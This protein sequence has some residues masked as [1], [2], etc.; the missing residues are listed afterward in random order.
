MTIS[1]NASG[2]RLAPIT[3]ASW[4]LR[5]VAVL[6]LVASATVVL[7]P[8]PAAAT[9]TNPVLGVY[10]GAAYP[11]SVRTF[12]ATIGTQPPFAMDFLN[13]STWRTITQQWPYSYWKGKGYT[14]VW[15]VNMLP[16][17]YTPNT[18]PSQAGGSC[19]GLTQGATG[20]FDHYFT[21]VA[22][23]IVKA[24]FPTSVIRF[25]WEFNGNW[26][27]W[28]AQGCASAFVR[29]WD[30]IVTTM[31]AVPGA[32]FTFEWN[33]TRGDLGVGNLAKYY[34]GN[35]YVDEVGLDVYDLEQDRYPGAKAEFQHMRTQTYGLNWLT[36]FA[37]AHHKDPVLPEWGL[38]WG[39]CSTSGQPITSLGNQVCGG[40]DGPW[41][42]LM[43]RWMTAHDVSEATYWDYST[44]AVRKGY[45][46]LTAKALTA[47]FVTPPG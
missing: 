17:T 12:T 27:P 7:R 24:G 6:A 19:Y 36:Q 29:Y 25:G 4:V 22:T 2:P 21:T 41:I 23:N 28:A 11:R 38:G 39:T 47:H 37:A 31:R 10:G 3:T 45:N 35:N 9:S 34:P 46:P 32:N 18:D 13:G 26:F 20:T 33:P 1:R 42:T 8:S 44:S 14:M 30:D 15:G 43:A 5:L 16:D 40:D